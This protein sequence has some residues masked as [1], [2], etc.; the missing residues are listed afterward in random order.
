MPRPKNSLL[1]GDCKDILP[2]L[3][4]QSIDHIICDLPYGVTKDT[5]DKRIPFDFMWS[6]FTRIMKPNGNIVLFGQSKFFAELIISNEKMY[7]YDIVWDKILT[8]GFLNSKKMPLRQHEHIAI[9]YEKQKVYNPQMTIGKPS[10]SKGTKHLKQDGVNKNYGDYVSV[11]TE[12]SDLKY[13]KSIVR[14]QKPHPSK[15]LHRTEKP[16]D[17]MEWIVKTYTNV[18]DTIL[19]P[20]CGSGTTL[21]AAKN[22]NRRYIGIEINESD[23][24]ISKNRL[25]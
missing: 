20:T 16:I 18:G 12:L 1:H 7:K 9:F 3:P 5:Y 24:L 25:K 6:E 4:T 19:D 14:F 10:H 22:L 17:L 21:L 8:S 2:Y 13:P 11:N 15:S 23:F